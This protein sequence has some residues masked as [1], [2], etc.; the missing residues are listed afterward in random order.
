MPGIPVYLTLLL[1]D[2]DHFKTVNDR[3]GHL[4]GDDILKA[5][6]RLLEQRFHRCT[7]VAARFGGEEF[8]VLLPD[9]PPDEAR[10]LAESL[11]QDMENLCL[12]REGQPVRGTVSIGLA[13]LVPDR[14]QSPES[15]V[16]AADAALY[17]AKRKGRNRTVMGAL[18]AAAQARPRVVER[19][20]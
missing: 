1:L 14:R 5:F 3:H 19:H 9:T 8:A 11:R 15:L 7:D 2:I 17:Q 12:V 6:A 18:P 10:C 16:A 13:G 20:R 4:A